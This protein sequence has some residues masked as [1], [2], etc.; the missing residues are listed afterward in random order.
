MAFADGL[1]VCE[2][3]VP[4]IVR[5]ENEPVP[6]VT[7]PV[8]LPVNGPANAVAV[9]VPDTSNVVVGVAKLG[10]IAT[11]L[12]APSMV[13]TVTVSTPSLTINCM[14]L[15]VTVFC[16]VTAPVLLVESMYN[17]KSLAVPIVRPEALLIVKEPAIVSEISD[18]TKLSAKTVAVDGIVT[19]SESADVAVPANFTPRDEFNVIPFV[20]EA[21]PVIPA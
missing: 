14:S 19:L 9:T 12:V 21:N 20:I 16:I 8:T 1:I 4:V 15:S 6:P 2:I 5:A 11:L 3:V 17:L 13:I 18:L 10:P 7:L